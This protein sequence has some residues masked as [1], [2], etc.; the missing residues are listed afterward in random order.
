MPV[1]IRSYFLS[2]ANKCFCDD[3]SNLFD[4][5]VIRQTFEQLCKQ[6]VVIW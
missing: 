3:F 2:A 1:S 5:F 4:I 6:T